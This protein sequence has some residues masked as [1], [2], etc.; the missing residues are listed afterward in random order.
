MFILIVV[1]FE[2][3]DIHAVRFPGFPPSGVVIETE[4]R[5]DKNFLVCN[6]TSILHQ[7]THNCFS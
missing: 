6:L 7:Y 5:M 3:C 4:E 1:V 2:S